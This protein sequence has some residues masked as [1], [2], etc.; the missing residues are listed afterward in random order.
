MPKVS[1]LDILVTRVT[2]KF[3]QNSK[4]NHNHM[5]GSFSLHG[6]VCSKSPLK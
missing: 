4:V 2:T 5:N 1:Y 3:K 6:K